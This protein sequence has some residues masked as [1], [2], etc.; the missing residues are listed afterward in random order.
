MKPDGLSQ[1]MPPATSSNV[2]GD[3]YVAKDECMG[4]GAPEAEAPDLIAFDEQSKA[5]SSNASQSSLKSS[6]E[7]FALFMHPA[8]V[9]CATAAPMKPCDKESRVKATLPPLMSH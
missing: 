6:T 2:S 7:L 4:C 9:L 1:T 3:F 5:A 8:V